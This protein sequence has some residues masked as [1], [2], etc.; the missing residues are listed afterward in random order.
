MR[1]PFLKKKRDVFDEYSPTD[2]RYAEEVPELRPFLSEE[3]FIRYKSGVEASLARTKAELGM[4]SQEDARLIEK[5]L[6]EVLAEEVYEEEKK[7]RHDIIA[8]V[9]VTKRKI[10]RLFRSKKSKEAA[11]K[12]RNAVHW[13]ATSYD[14]V[15]PANMK[16]YA[17]AFNNVILPQIVD[18]M[19]AWIDVTKKEADTLQIGRTHLQHA[20]PITFGFAYAWYL[21][22]LGNRLMKIQD[23]INA[24]EGKFSGAVGAYN[25]TSLFVEDPED[26]E[27]R[28]LAD[29]G[30][31]PAE[32]STQIAPPEPVDDLLHYTVSAFGVLANWADDTRD[33]MRPEI[34][35]VMIPRGPDVSRSSTMPHKQNPVGPENVKSLWKRAMP[36]MI[37]MYMDQISDHQRD[38]TNSASQRYTPEIFA[39]F[40]YAV[41]RTA[42]V[43]RSFVTRPEMMKR[44]LEMS[45]DKIMAEPLQIALSYAG[46]PNAHAYVGKIADTV[47]GKT[48]SLVETVYNDREAAPYVSR[49][50]ES[51][52]EILADPSS[53][54]GIASQKA[55]KIADVWEQRLRDM[56]YVKPQ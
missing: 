5:Y 7:T 2:F 23:G 46:H 50:T 44:N 51:Q 13:P 30:L 11:E 29:Y 39:I 52:R 45:G 40:Y 32:I 9:N 8:Q 24:L 54:T 43:S 20:E 37:T 19:Y 49:F 16:R 3:A 6:P 55:L 53:Y 38:L 42:R 35:E 22:R 4:I 36:H 12:A 17:D 33:L 10:G 48:D 14:K 28:V 47:S 25:A 21:S 56:G 15:D 26:F 18:L 27:R 1:I 34:G 41:K 31:R